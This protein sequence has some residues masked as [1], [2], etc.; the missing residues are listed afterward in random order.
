MFISIVLVIIN[1][2]S[3]L[4]N[5]IG[6]LSDSANEIR[7]LSDSATADKVDKPKYSAWYTWNS[8][9]E[10]DIPVFPNFV[11]PVDTDERNYFVIIGKCIY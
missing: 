7:I 1:C 5:E 8:E 3:V 6:I 10:D 11:W 4:S 2:V 9:L